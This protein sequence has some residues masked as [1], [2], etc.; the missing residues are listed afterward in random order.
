MLLCEIELIWS[1]YIEVLKL[2]RNCE[3]LLDNP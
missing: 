2:N 1:I 3:G